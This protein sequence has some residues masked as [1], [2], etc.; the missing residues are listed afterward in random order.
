MDRVL[1]IKPIVKLNVHVLTYNLQNCIK[2]TPQVECFANLNRKLGTHLN[3]FIVLCVSSF[4]IRQTFIKESLNFV[5]SKF[6]F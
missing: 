3:H 4:D 2:F 5:R 1:H 6:Q